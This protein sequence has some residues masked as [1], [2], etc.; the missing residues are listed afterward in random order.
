MVHGNGRVYLS[1]THTIAAELIGGP[2]PKRDDYGYTTRGRGVIDVA[3]LRVAGFELGP[4]EDVPVFDFGE[5]GAVPFEGML[6]TRF[7]VA[8]RAAVDFA[9]DALL[10]GVPVAGA[11]NAT[12][13]DDGYRAVPMRVLEDGGLTIEVGFAA[14][15]RSVPITPSTVSVALTLH[16]P[17]FAELVPMVPTATPDRSPG[18]TTPDVFTAD[19]VEFEIGGVSYQSGASFMDLAEYANSP[20]AEPPSYGMLGFDWMRAHRAILDYANRIL[21]VGG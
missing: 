5:P 19:A 1:L 16:R 7:L 14:L 4:L 8:E 17:A 9:R 20:E 6:G 21:Y 13:V 15:G 12:L 11:P 10:L 3:S 2:V 18:G